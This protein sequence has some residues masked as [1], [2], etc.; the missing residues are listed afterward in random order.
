L[1]Q[2]MTTKSAGLTLALVHLRN[3]LSNMANP[4]RP[5]LGVLRL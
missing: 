1:N 3:N 4:F 2:V 5:L